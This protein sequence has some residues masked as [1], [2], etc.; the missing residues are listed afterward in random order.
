MSRLIDRGLTLAT[1]ES[2]TGGG[3]GAAVTDI[4][5]SSACFLGG[6]IAYANRVKIEQLGVPAE[7]LAEHGAVSEPVARAMA[8]GVRARLGA[9]IRGLDHRHRRSGRRDRG[10]AG[11]HRRRRG[12]HRPRDPLQTAP[13]LRQARHRSPRRDHLGPQVDPR[14]ARP[15]RPG[16]P[17]LIRSPGISPVRSPPIPAKRALVRAYR[18]RH[19]VQLG[20]RPSATSR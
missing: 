14:S 7:I 15:A 19:L 2:C 17:E 13:P 16:P 8:E 4:A 18:H 20:Q 6:V 3:I 9:S 10:K 12:R 5:G 1:A 11:R